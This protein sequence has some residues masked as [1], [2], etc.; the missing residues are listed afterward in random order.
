MTELGIIGLVLMI[1][2]LVRV[3][4]ELDLAD[5]AGGDRFQIG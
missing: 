5:D 4:W 3:W 1:A 2:W